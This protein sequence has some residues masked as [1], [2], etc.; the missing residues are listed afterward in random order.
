MHSLFKNLALDGG[1]IT[2]DYTFPNGTY[3]KNIGLLDVDYGANIIVVH[4]SASGYMEY[5]IVVPLVGDDAA[6]TVEIDQANVKWIKL[7]L[8]RSGGITDVTFCSL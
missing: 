8:E 7:E 4:E 6:Q 5:T 2:L 3:V 1:I